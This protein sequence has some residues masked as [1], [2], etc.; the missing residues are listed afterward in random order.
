MK[1]ERLFT[2]RR[3]KGKMDLVRY[4]LSKGANTEIPMPAGSSQST[5]W[6]KASHLRALPRQVHLLQHP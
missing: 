3:R 6:A 4:L 5:W 2:S 1:A